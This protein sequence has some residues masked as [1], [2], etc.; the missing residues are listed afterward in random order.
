[1]PISNNR[2]FTTL[3]SSATTAFPAAVLLIG[4]YGRGY[5]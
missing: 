3:I 4:G 1:M 2:G 5:R